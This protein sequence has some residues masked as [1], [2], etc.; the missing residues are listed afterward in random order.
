[1]EPFHEVQITLCVL[2]KTS[3]KNLK[4]PD[5]Q[6]LNAPLDVCNVP[7]NPSKMIIL[8]ES[9]YVLCSQICIFLDRKKHIFFSVDTPEQGRISRF[10]P[11]V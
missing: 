9:Y 1:M 8:C 5:A 7:K 2:N 3:D 4:S 11:V 10:L 6:T